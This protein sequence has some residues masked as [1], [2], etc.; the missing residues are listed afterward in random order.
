MASSSF[1][2]AYLVDFES[3]LNIQDNEGMQNMFKAL[4]NS[5]L[6]G[7]LGSKSM[8]YE[9]ELEQI[10]DT[11]LIQGGDITGSISGKYFSFSPSRFAGVFE[12]PTEGLLDFSD[13][14]WS[15]VLFG[16]LEEMVDRT[17]KKAK[18]YGAQISVLLN[19]D[20]ALTM[21]E[22]TPFPSS[23]ILSPKTVLTYITT[24]QTADTRGQSDEAGKTPVAI[25][26]RTSKSKKKSESTSD[27]T[28][29]IVSEVVG[30]KKRPAVEGSEPVVPKKRRTMK[31]K[32]SVSSANM[33]M[34]SVAQGAVP[35]Q[36][37]EPTPA[38]TAEQPH[39]PKRKSRKRRLNSNVYVSNKCSV[40]REEQCLRQQRVLLFRGN[41][42]AYVIITCWTAIPTYSISGT[43]AHSQ[44]SEM[45]SSSFTNAYLV[46]FES[47]L[48]IQ[49]NEGMQNMFKALENSGLRGFKQIGV[50]V[51]T[52]TTTNQTADTR[53][54]SDEGGKTPV[55]TVKRASISK[56][57]SESTSDATVEIVSEVV[58]SKKRPAVEG[59]EPVVPKKRRTMKSKASVS[60]ANMDMASVAQGAVPLQVIEPT[61][62]VTAEQPRAPKRK[63]RKRRL[64]L[65]EGSGDDN[66]EESIDVAPTTDK[67]DVIIGQIL[68]ETSKL[69]TDD[70]E[71]GEQIFTETD[72]G[73]IAFGDSTAANPEELAQWIENYISEGAE[74][75]NGSD[76]D[77]VQGTVDIVDDEQLFET[78]NVEEAEGSKS[79]V[80]EKDMNIAIGS[81]HTEE[82]LMSI[83]DLLLQISDDILL[84]PVTAAEITK[85]RLGESIYINEVQEHDLYYAS[86][87]RISSHDKGKEI[88]EED[89]PVKGNPA[90][91]TVELI[92]GDVDFLV[93]LRDKVMQD[94][95][96]FFHSF[97]L[98]KLS[99]LY[100][101]LEF[102]AKEKLMLEWAETDSLET[103][104]KRK[105]WT[106]TASQIIDLLSDAHSKSLEDLIAQ[107][108]EHGLPME[109]LCTSTFLDA[110]VGG[111]AVLAQLFSQAKSTC[112]VRPMVL[113]DDVWTPIQG[114]DFWR[115]S[116]KLSLFV[117]RKKLPETV[118][119][120]NFVPHVFFIEPVQ[121]WGAAPSLIK[122][123]HWARVCTDVIRFRGAIIL[124]QEEQL[125]FV[126]SPES[127][128]ATSPCL[129]TS[130]SSTS[131]SIHFD[132]DDIPLDD[133]ADI[134]TSV[135]VG[136]TK[137]VEAIDDL[138]TLLIQRINYSNG[139][140]LSKLNT[141]DRGVLD[142][143]RHQHET[144]RHSLQAIRQ[145]N[146]RQGDSQLIHIDHFK[147]G[148]AAHGLNVIENFVDVKKE[149]SAQDSKITALDWQTAAIRSE[150]LEFQTKIAADLLSLST[151]LGDIVDYIRGGDAKKGE[152]SRSRRPLSTPVNQGKSSGNVV[153]TAE[154]SQ[155]DID[156]AQRDI[157]ERMMTAD[158]ERERIERSRGSKSGS[159]AY[160]R[161]LRCVV[162]LRDF[163]R[164]ADRM[165]LR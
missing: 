95:I 73:D 46:D 68:T 65:S 143:L 107:Q 99:D 157:V 58:G 146:Q 71:S 147:K 139:E 132:A 129:E 45:A 154:T 47:V 111:G 4:E 7:F 38:V 62:A 136:R 145:D 53:G 161:A 49:D 23:K 164:S 28:V 104:V 120:D 117:N 30:S 61:P 158:R 10:F 140:I 50:T 103:A 78:A 91:E 123:W 32:A 92:C 122:T 79:P 131:L 33:D 57:K 41:R 142:A 124:A 3:V 51:L 163:P 19:S 149:L 27:A 56:K 133:T 44:T 128:P 83:D 77:R 112:W 72:V 135:P 43:F 39:A 11:A 87:P 94:V 153:R 160:V 106:A 18:V 21:G 1:T 52:Y 116:C 114:T 67:V 25:V 127:P 54:K 63:S 159:R 2:N 88:L 165:F 6:R 35:L 134:Q 37:I 96:E 24:N 70:T 130:T 126:Q 34:A 109:Q 55:A 125:Y 66:V 13:V 148:V 64:I 100:S 86:L 42:H 98:N 137:F 119:E 162:V 110:S 84:P 141:V 15:K 14:N 113:I 80:V 22:A 82:E 17:V 151:Q 144:L 93:Q 152:G 138:R 31:S 118:I 108:K 59:S 60:S 5:G 20:P 76:S 12:L 40:Q 36:V 105:P 115:S 102:K 85:I 121:Y 97:S 69:T 101:L 90:R 75:V 9:P 150:Q 48:N 16:V 26:K 29:E 89:E 155:R 74:K 8:L 81:K 156:N